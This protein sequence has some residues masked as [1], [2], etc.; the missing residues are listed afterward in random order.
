M[1]TRPSHLIAHSISQ[2]HNC[3]LLKLYKKKQLRCFS[4]Q[5][6]PVRN[7]RNSSREPSLVLYVQYT[8]FLRDLKKIRPAADA[9]NPIIPHACS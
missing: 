6:K 8:R 5:T 3:L 9:L 4:G 2:T 7:M 1:M